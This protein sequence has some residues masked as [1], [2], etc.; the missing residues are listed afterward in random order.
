[1][2]RIEIASLLPYFLRLENGQYPTQFDGK[3]YLLSL[4][5]VDSASDGL[6]STKLTQ[7]SFVFTGIAASDDEVQ[8]FKTYQVEGLLRQTNRLL[9]WYRAST[10]LATVTELTRA[11]ASP[12]LFRI[13]GERE[14]T[15]EIWAQEIRFESS[16]LPLASGQTVQTVTEAVRKGLTGKNDPEVSTLFLLDAEQALLEGRFRESVLFCWS[17]IDSTFDRKYKTLISSV[18]DDKDEREALTNFRNA[19]MRYRM[20]AGLHFCTGASLYDQP[21]DLWTKLFTSYGKRNL[22]IHD[23]A[24]AQEADA[25]LAL[26]VA[27]QVISFLAVL[28]PKK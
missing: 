23:G 27:R 6:S 21:N 15:S 28:K 2:P 7:V 3:S 14:N 19:S 5:D 12:Y 10:G 8:R 9:R 13:L 18:I 25:E 22:I 26:S 17:A 4:Q 11:Q 24:S 1:M 16:P 20:S